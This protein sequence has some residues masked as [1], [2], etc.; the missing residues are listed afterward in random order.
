MLIREKLPN[1]NVF[2]QY[3]KDFKFEKKKANTTPTLLASPKITKLSPS[4]KV[5]SKSPYVGSLVGKKG[6]APS[7]LFKY[8]PQPPQPKVVG[9]KVDS[10]EVG[11]DM[12]PPDI[13]IP[14]MEINSSTISPKKDEEMNMDDVKR[15]PNTSIVESGK[16]TDLLT[17]KKLDILMS[18]SAFLEKRTP[19]SS[20]A[21]CSC[22]KMC[23]IGKSLCSA[24]AGHENAGYLYLKQESKLKRYWYKM[25]N[26]YLFQYDNVEDPTHKS[27]VALQ[28]VVIK[29][30]LEEIIDSKTILHPFTLS[31]ANKGK[32]YYALK[33]EERIKWLKAIREDIGCY[34]F[35]DYYDMKEVLGKGK[36]GLVKMAI[37]KSSKK[38]VAIKIMKKK[39]MNAQ[40][41]ELV[42]REI[43]I[44]KICQHPNI[45]RLLD[46]FENSD[47][48]FIVMEHLKGGDLFTYLEKKVQYQR[49][50]SCIHCILNCSSTLVFA[51]IW[52]CSQRS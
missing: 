37:H 44:L 18:P 52:N 8:L 26:K 27:M 6:V 50:K 45:I 35:S 7:T 51:F 29:E 3:K 2:L 33:K 49:A 10:C 13:I 19:L 39:D 24:C 30:E 40:D 46:I 23:E 17:A 15:L 28:G 41:I 47:Y 5:L 38:S 14:V 1:M 31:C 34:N 25:A 12:A 11:S 43:E 22:G 36:F 9:E 21:V 42:R 16:I 20:M 32:T 4:M 48:I